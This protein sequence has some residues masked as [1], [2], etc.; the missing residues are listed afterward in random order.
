M[1]PLD[2]TIIEPVAKM[3]YNC[4]SWLGMRISEV[5]LVGLGRAT[6]GGVGQ[7]HQLVPG[8]PALSHRP[9]VLNL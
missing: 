4:V 6:L 7:P 2:Q 8:G 3:T 1:W 9:L 5:A